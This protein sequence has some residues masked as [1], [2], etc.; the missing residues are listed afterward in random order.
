MCSTVWGVRIGE[1]NSDSR[2]KTTLPASPA[3]ITTRSL[4]PMV[5][6]FLYHD[7]ER[8]NDCLYNTVFLSVYVR[9]GKLKQHFNH[10]MGGI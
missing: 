10:K 7:I 9:F 1:L 5:S 6:A 8:V 3:N 2:I 4:V